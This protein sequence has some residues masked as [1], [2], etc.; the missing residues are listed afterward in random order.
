MLTRSALTHPLNRR[1]R[2]QVAERRRG[3]SADVCWAVQHTSFVSSDLNPI[4]VTY[5]LR[6]KSETKQASKQTNEQL[7]NRVKSSKRFK[8]TFQP[9]NRA[10]LRRQALILRRNERQISKLGR[11]QCG[12]GCEFGRKHAGDASGI[13]QSSAPFAPSAASAPANQQHQQPQQQ[14]QQPQQ[15]QLVATQR[16][17]R[18]QQ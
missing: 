12:W 7:N 9:Q 18:A 13:Q 5:L 10:H 16:R 14:P 8:E 17:R 15:Q 6:P 1:R 4:T 11:D 3:V 2:E